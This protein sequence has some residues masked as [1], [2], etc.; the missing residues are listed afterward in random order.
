MDK[1][2]LMVSIHLISAVRMFSSGLRG[3]P[4][5]SAS[6]ADGGGGGFGGGLGGGSGSGSLAIPTRTR[7]NF[8]E[9]WLW[10]NSTTG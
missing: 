5:P 7:K 3:R 4:G 8:P 9:T 6:F 10:V 2:C 1:F